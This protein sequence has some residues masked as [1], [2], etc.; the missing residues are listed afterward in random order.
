MIEKRLHIEINQI[1]MTTRA[2]SSFRIKI[3]FSFETSFIHGLIF[4]SIN[5]VIINNTI[6]FKMTEFDLFRANQIHKNNVNK[7]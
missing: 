7:T 5:K 1:Q 2:I 6:L 4:F 3:S